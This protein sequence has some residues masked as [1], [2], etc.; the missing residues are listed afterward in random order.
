MTDAIP[1]QEIEKYMNRFELRTDKN[2]EIIF[3]GMGNIHK[4]KKFIRNLEGTKNEKI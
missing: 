2:G 3:N 4:L 1:K